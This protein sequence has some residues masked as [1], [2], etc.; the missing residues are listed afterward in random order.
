M[1]S[2]G[3]TNEKLVAV[4]AILFSPAG[5]LLQPTKLSVFMTALENKA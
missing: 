4:I 2:E 3:S 5:H 1:M